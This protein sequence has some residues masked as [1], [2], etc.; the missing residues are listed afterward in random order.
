MSIPDASTA[1]PGHLL[2]SQRLAQIVDERRDRLSFSDLAE[3]LGNRAWGALLF[4]FAIVNVLPLPPGAN[5]IL[6]IPML[7]VAAQIVIGREKPWF[8]RWI[9]RRGVTG[10]QLEMVANKVSSVECRTHRL[11]KPRLMRLSGPTAARV[12][13]LACLLLGLLAAVP[14]PVLHIAPAAGIALFGLALTY[15][16]GVLV[17]VAALASVAAIAVDALILGSGVVALSYIVTWLH[18]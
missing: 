2:L 8:P 15:R 4:I 5:M 3:E 17:I 12:I 10:V 11:F 1:E 6:A 13:G 9:D 18:R 14:I 16:D 7:F